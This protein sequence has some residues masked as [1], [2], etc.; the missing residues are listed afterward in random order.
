MAKVPNPPSEPPP[1]PRMSLSERYRLQ[2]WFLGIIAFG[3]VLFLLVQA[4]FILTS[5]VFAMMLFS[6]TSE[7]INAFSQLRIGSWRITNFVAS[8][9]AFTLIAVVLLTLTTIVISQINAMVSTTIAYADQAI[10]AVSRLAAW[11]SPEAQASVE[12][13]IRSIQLTSYL[14]PLAGQASNLLSATTLVLLF[15]GFL[16]AERFWFATK[17]EN[18]FHDKAQAERVSRIIQSIARRVNRYLMVKTGISLGTGLAVYALML[19]FDI[20]FAGPLGIATF[21]LNYIP[22][23]G[24]IV[25][26]I[27]VG[28]VAFM[29][30][31]DPSF[32]LLVL[33]LVTLIQFLLGNV[34]DPM[35]MGRALQV[36]A[37]GIM[38]SLAFWGAIWG[39]PGMFLAVPILVAMMIICSHIPAARPFAV[40]ISREGLPD[41]EDD[42]L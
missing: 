3:M 31:G 13:S 15:V 20:Q 14:T 21:V 38:V 33:V 28:L 25:A 26:T 29:Q 12:T 40:L 35:L 4:Q 34:V 10:L 42:A 1:P 24:S 22:T 19:F 32:A 8:V 16:F 17:L 5:L 18:L 37:L 36:S 6:L 7:A 11:I 23:I 2:T 27:L 9:A 41:L 30:A 39:V